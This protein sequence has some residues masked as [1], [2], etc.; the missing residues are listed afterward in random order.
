M[1]FLSLILLSFTLSGCITPPDVRWLASPLRGVVTLRGAPVANAKVTRS[2][3]SHWYNERVENSAV[4]GVNGTFEFKGAWKVTAASFLHQPIIKIAVVVEHAGES[5]DVLSTTKMNYERFGEL[6]F[7]LKPIPH[8][9][10]SKDVLFLSC[11]LA[12]MSPR[13]KAPSNPAEPTTLGGG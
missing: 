3:H 6:T 11:D 10:R 8:L 4:T 13:S 9:V 12:T 7:P 2:Y 1:R 5:F